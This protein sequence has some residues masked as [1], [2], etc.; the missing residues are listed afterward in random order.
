M[1]RRTSLSQDV[2]RRALDARLDLVGHYLPR[3]ADA[4]DET[5]N[6]HQL[7]VATRRAMAA[8]QIF[9]ALSAAPPRACG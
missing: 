1:L 8:M 9:D 4:A 5:E 6:V 7:R 2:A 3:A